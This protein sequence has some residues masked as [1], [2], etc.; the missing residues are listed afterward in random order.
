LAQRYCI[1]FAR[2]QPLHE[3]FGLRNVG[4]H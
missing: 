3:G 1:L 2:L 4:E